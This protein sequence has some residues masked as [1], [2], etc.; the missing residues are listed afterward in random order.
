MVETELGFRGGRPTPAGV[1][2]ELPAVKPAPAVSTAPVPE[3]RTPS[4]WMGGRLYDLG[5]FQLS[6]LASLLLLVSYFF[7][8]PSVVFPIYNFYLIFFGLPHNYMTWAS[9][10][11]K[12]CR[13]TFNM[14]PIYTAAIASVAICI[15]IPFTVGSNLNDWLLSFISYYSFWHAYRQ[16]HGICKV[17]D[18][19]QARR[20]GDPSI[21]AD[22]KAM[23][24]F[25]G[26]AAN[27]VLVWAFTHGKI[28]Y[29]LSLDER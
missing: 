27:A 1:P 24:L 28:Y 6:G 22:R 15:L 20:T 25:F 19:I 2:A 8:G 9:I 13:K 16:H 29:L 7:Q 17:Y 3:L 18:S 23:N 10:F 5:F 11:P 26:F 12:S 21:F 14:S 4:L